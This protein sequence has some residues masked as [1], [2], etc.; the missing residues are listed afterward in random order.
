MWENLIEIA[1]AGGTVLAVSIFAYWAATKWKSLY[2]DELRQ[3]LYN[4]PNQKFKKIGLVMVH[5]IDTAISTAEQVVVDI[6]GKSD[7]GTTT[8]ISTQTLTP[9]QAEGLGLIK[10]DSILTREID[11]YDE[12]EILSIMN[13]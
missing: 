1:V 8:K 3:W 10:K 4:H 2:R 9:Q 12:A 5:A 6:V 11:L 13:G 7:S